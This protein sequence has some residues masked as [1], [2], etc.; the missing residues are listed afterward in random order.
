MEAGCRGWCE[1]VK[2]ARDF[3]GYRKQSFAKLDS[4]KCFGYSFSMSIQTE[5]LIRICEAL[6]EDKR[7]EVADFAQ[8]L[9]DRLDD[10][11]WER[12][13]ADPKPRPKLEAFMDASR[14]EG[15]EKPLDLDLL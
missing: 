10:A 8:F 6:P 14:A 4:S 9:L 3:L 15:G 5:E 2:I 11:R 13:I 1:S 7:A 12:L